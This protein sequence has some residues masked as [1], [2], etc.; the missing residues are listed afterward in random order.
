L[1]PPFLRREEKIMKVVAFLPAKGS[2]SRIDRKNINLLDGKPLFLHTLE[3]LMQCDF[4]HEVYLDTDSE[5]IIELAS[6]VQCNIMRRDPRFATNKTD[7][8]QLFMNEVRFVE[9]DIYIQILCTSP[10]IQIETL[11]KGVEALQADYSEY[12]SVVLVR[13]D[14]QYTWKEGVPQYDIE[15]I[16]NSIDL[17]ETVIETMGL[18][19]VKRQSALATSRRIGRR[20][21]LIEASP[22]EAIDVNWIEDFNLANL[23]AAGMREQDRKLLINIKN[24]LTSSIL[25]DILDDFGMHNQVIRGLSP[26]LEDVKCLGRAKTL[27]LRMLEKDEDFRGIYHALNSYSSIIPHDIIVVENEASDYAYFGELNANLAIRSGASAI[28]VGGKTRDSLEVKRMQL[29]VF[30]T[31]YSCQDVRKRATLDSVNKIIKINGV[32]I[33]PG[34]LIF[35]DPDGLIVIPK[36]IEKDVISEIYKRS[37]IEKNITVDISLGVEV[38]A[39]V[40]KYGFF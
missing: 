7:G 37:S 2:S 13:N 34:D 38:G 3:K 17:P 33:S 18:Y 25:S 11:K 6:L 23:I 8:N 40:E 12:D 5:E 30:S 9:A 15:R 26:N 22:L 36:R 32:T 39:L 19:I 21:L 31:G 27:K 14:K 10:F 35:G 24:I 1:N 28:I 4:I 29:P 20:P 16:P